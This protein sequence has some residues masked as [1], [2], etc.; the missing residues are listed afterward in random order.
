MTRTFSFTGA[1][2][3]L[4]VPGGV[5]TVDVDAFGAQ[6]G[7]GLVG[8]LPGSGGETVATVP[9][10][11]GETLTI[12]VGGRGGAGGAGTAGA[13]GFNGGAP[14]G[15]S[16]SSGGGGGGASDVRR[17]AAALAD[18]IVVAGG[19]GGSGADSGAA[20]GAGGGL[21]GLPGGDVLPCSG[22]GGGTQAAGGPGGATCD[23]PDGAS[24]TAGA[25]GGGAS[26]VDSGGGGGGGG[27][28]GG[29][30]G[31]TVGPEFEGGGGG[32]GGGGGSSFSVAG[33][34]GVVHT[35]GV[36]VGD[37]VVTITYLASTLIVTKAGAGTGTVTSSPGGIACGATCSAEFGDGTTVDLAAAADPGSV[38]GGF[39]GDCTGMACSVVMGP[40]RAVTATF[41]VALPAPGPQAHAVLLKVVTQGAGTGAAEASGTVSSFPG[42]IACARSGGVD[43]TGDCDEQYASAMPV[44]V[45]A[46]P[47][48][49]TTA[50]LAGACTAPAAGPG[51]AVAC[52]T[53]TL[54]DDVVTATFTRE[55]PPAPEIVNLPP[56]LSCPS[57]W[58]VPVAPAG[59]I[60]QSI[61]VTADDPNADQIVA[62]TETGPADLVSRA[63]GTLTY[64]PTIVD[65]L[66]DL[67]PGLGPPDEVV[68]ATDNGSPPLAATCTIQVDVVLFAGSPL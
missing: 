37:G 53:L 54:R 65:W 64:A 32:A 42:G 13:G 2:Q 45:S 14:G 24:G 44:T 47:G 20:G 9:V 27:L 6:G 19:G 23:G 34:T 61:A 15:T 33:A 63:A 36:R 67:W 30:G 29:G 11:P 39:S 60:G 8:G 22:G 52:T 56:T 25:G 3:A 41:G 17:G 50:A 48:A 12:L 68:Q 57:A 46:F 38:F 16:P 4:V 1:A 7:T 55:G 43:T 51:E 49:A 18:R 21:I 40:D 62:L 28:F 31:E 10:T 59:A 66:F 5:T 58:S 26:G 35:Q